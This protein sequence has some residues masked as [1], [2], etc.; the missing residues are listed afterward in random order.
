MVA[1]YWILLSGALSLVVHGARD[2]IKL[3][4]GLLVLLNAFAMLVETMA[5]D[6][7]SDVALGLLGVS[8]VALVLVISYLLVVLKVTFLDADL[9]DIFDVRA[10]ITGDEMALVAVGAGEGDYFYTEAAEPAL[11]AAGEVGTEKEL[12]KPQSVKKQKAKSKRQKAEVSEEK[13]AEVETTPVDA[14][15]EDGVPVRG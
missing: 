7:L 5:L 2:L 8:R 11:D 13:P 6:T 15:E 14:E 4:V 9:D 3:G 12:G 10:G 1:F